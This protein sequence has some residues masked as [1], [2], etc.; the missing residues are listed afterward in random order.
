MIFTVEDIRR[1]SG[2]REALEERQNYDRER[3]K[4]E[5]TAEREQREACKTREAET[6]SANWYAVVDGRI[7][8]HLKSWLWKAIDE[9]ITQWWNDNAIDERITQLWDIKCEPFKDAIGGALG[10][11]RAA[12]RRI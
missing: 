8:E 5:F 11:T 6:A 1:S 10:K 7:H 4:R 12:A 9:H 3:R 2:W